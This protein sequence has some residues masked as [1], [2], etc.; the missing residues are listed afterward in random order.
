MVEKFSNYLIETK[1]ALK[2]NKNK[3]L[4]MEI[5]QHMVENRVFTLSKPGSHP[6]KQNVEDK[7]TKSCLNLKPNFR[8]SGETKVSLNNSHT[9][10]KGTECMSSR[11]VSDSSES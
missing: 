5:K 9:E 11:K 2:N 10:G 4:Y 1:T 6:C 7:Y 3:V 8:I